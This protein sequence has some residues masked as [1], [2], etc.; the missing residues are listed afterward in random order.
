MA[1]LANV[2]WAGAGKVI[3][4]FAGD[5][6]GEYPSTELVIDGAGND[7]PFPVVWVDLAAA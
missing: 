5:E 6:N 7:R 3:F 2:A 4:S 1:M